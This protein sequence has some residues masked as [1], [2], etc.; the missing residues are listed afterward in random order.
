MLKGS[1]AHVALVRPFLR[2][3]ALVHT[4][5]LLNR[6]RLVAVLALVRLLAGVGAVVAREA[7]RHRERLPA[8]VTLVRVLALFG[9][10]FQM[11]R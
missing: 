10:R 8:E 4:Q 11:R 2:V 6:E 7:R 1:C 9:M 5:V 3:D